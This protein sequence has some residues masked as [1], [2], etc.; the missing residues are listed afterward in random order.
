MAMGMT[1]PQSPPLVLSPDTRSADDVERET[2]PGG[3]KLQCKLTSDYYNRALSG[4][5][6][7]IE[8]WRYVIISLN[9]L[10]SKLQIA[11]IGKF[12]P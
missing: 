8:P 9:I 5:E 12:I 7:F 11:S 4:W 10:T 6:P 2:G 1:S 3:G